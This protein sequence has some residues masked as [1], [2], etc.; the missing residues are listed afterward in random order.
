MLLLPIYSAGEA[1]IAGVT[2]A[3]L[4]RAI[5]D[6]GGTA[7]CFDSLEHLAQELHSH[8]RPG[9]LILAMGA[10][11]INQLPDLVRSAVPVAV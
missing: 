9:D 11:S 6:A 3:A 1:S 4:A 5:A 7:H 10:G 2:H 8:T